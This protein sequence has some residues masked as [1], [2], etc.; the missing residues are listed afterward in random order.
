M[1]HEQHGFISDLM[2]DKKIKGSLTGIVDKM[3]ETYDGFIGGFCL[4]VNRRVVPVMV[5]GT[6]TGWKMQRYEDGVWLDLDETPFESIKALI[7]HYQ[8]E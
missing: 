7:A 2:P 5:N 8:E 3:N 1:L 6:V 4:G